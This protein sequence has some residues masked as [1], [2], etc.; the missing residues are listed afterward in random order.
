MSAIV[1]KG[2]SSVEWPGGLIVKHGVIRED[3]FCLTHCQDQVGSMVRPLACCHSGGKRWGLANC[4]I[5]GVASNVREGGAL[6]TACLAWTA[7][8]S[9]LCPAASRSS[10]TIFKGLRWLCHIFCRC[11]LH[12]PQELY[13]GRQGTPE[14]E[15]W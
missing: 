1:N 3:R 11:D 6:I 4:P 12:L 15:K 5:R 2:H 14:T 13:G 7:Y 9:L 8:S 10:L